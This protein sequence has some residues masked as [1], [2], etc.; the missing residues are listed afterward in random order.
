MAAAIPREE[1][2]VVWEFFQKNP[3]S[4]SSAVLSE[5]EKR[6]ARRASRA[7]RDPE[8]VS[9]TRVGRMIRRLCEEGLLKGEGETRARRYS[10]TKKQFN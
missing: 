4:S 6:E 10:T 5:L 3:A 2:K 7:S 8:P 9:A 1:L